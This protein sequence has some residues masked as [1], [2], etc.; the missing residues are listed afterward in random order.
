[1]YHLLKKSGQSEF[2][3]DKI[4]LIVFTC[5]G[6]EHLLPQT[7]ESFR[8]KVNYQF[9]K[10]VL[11]IDGKIS[12]QIL[13][14]VNPDIVVN[15]YTRKG[16]IFNILNAISLIET[17]FFF[18][19]EDDWHFQKEL[20]ID[21]ALEHIKS[22]MSIAEAT[23]GKY[24]TL[25][26]KESDCADFIESPFGFSANPSLCRTKIIK[27]AFQYLL[28]IPK[29]EFTKFTGFET[30]I[31]DFFMNNAISCCIV[32][33]KGIAH[34]KHSGDLET[35]P[36]E[37]HMI[38]SLDSSLSDIGREYISGNTFQSAISIKSKFS[39]FPKLLVS[40]LLILPK[41]FKS[42]EAY[43]ICIRSYFLIAKFIAKKGNN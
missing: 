4:T 20:N 13:E 10:V 38:N 14:I 33:P 39:I 2:K 41:V 15:N 37:Y 21:S 35:T 16:Y 34:S 27:E 31:S 6:R 42:R 40:V 23:F 1:M 32:N 22:S 12:K 24:D 3:M 36:R 25:K 43:D 8:E 9:S 11:A 18:W 26:S 28:T 17:D 30:A 5:E 19:L 29:N 7:L